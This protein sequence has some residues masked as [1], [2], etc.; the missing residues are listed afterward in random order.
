[1][2]SEIKY[3]LIVANPHAGILDN[4]FPLVVMSGINNTDH[5]DFLI[6]L[7]QFELLQ[8][9]QVN[10]DI[11][12]NLFK[13]WSVIISGKVYMCSRSVIV[14]F[15]MIRKIFSYRLF[16]FNKLLTKTREKVFTLFLKIFSSS[17]VVNYSKYNYVIGDLY[18]FTRKD[19]GLFAEKI[20][21]IK[22]ISISHCIN[23]FSTISRKYIY[24]LPKDIKYIALT[25]SELDGA[26][27]F[28]NDEQVSIQIDTSIGALRHSNAWNSCLLAM[29]KNVKSRLREKYIFV[30]S[31]APDSVV[32]EDEM[33]MYYKSIFYFSINS[34]L[35]VI[36][37]P[38]PCEQLK[39]LNKLVKVTNSNIGADVIISTLPLPLLIENCEFGVEFY[40]AVGADFVANKKVLVQCA[41]R[42]KLTSPHISAPYGEEIIS[43][44]SD[45]SKIAS[46]ILECPVPYL[47]KMK[48][49]YDRVIFQPISNEFE[50]KIATSHI[51]KSFLTETLH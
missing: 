46:K 51:I 29:L 7:D 26:S 19:A 45:F 31:R 49:I 12:L 10:R 16:S 41:D 22:F 32:S 5:F 23:P 14:A 20:R 50:L 6:R 8:N 40:S 28:K 39:K 21:N 34:G 15:L 3:G 11:A 36:I 25:K 1:M 33:I 35:S 43:N 42:E 27:M 47:E 24:N 17:T 38:H 37:K 30:V 4:I 9:N 44:S 18:L 48:K 2:T 13:N